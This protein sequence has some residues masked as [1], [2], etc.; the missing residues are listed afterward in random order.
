MLQ[1]KF[2]ALNVYVRYKQTKRFNY[3]SFHHKELEKDKQI[4]IQK[5]KR[6]IKII[7]GSNE[8]ENKQKKLTKQKLIF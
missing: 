7:R 2:I 8:L 4:K 1:G 5:N 3:L 6:I